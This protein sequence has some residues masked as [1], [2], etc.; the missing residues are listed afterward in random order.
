VRIPETT[1]RVPLT[2]GFGVLLVLTVTATV[3]TLTKSFDIFQSLGESHDKYD[4]VAEALQRLRSDLYLA[5]IMKRDFLLERDPEEAAS[6]GEQFA[7]IQ[8]SADNNLA[9]IEEGLGGQ[10]FRTIV[11]LRS[12]V[13]AYMRPLKEA[14]DWDPILAAPL[15]IFL[16]RAQLKQRTAALQ[17]AADRRRDR[18]A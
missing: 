6:Y 15:R 16:L 12:E 5:G 10:Q 4:R 2:L 11:Q 13:R 3:V 17:S 8:A 14:L 7:K 9:V 18:E 1:I